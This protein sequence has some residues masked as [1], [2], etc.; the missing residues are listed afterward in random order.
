MGASY[1]KKEL[2]IYKKSSTSCPGCGFRNDFMI[3][4]EISCS[5]HT[6]ENEE[7]IFRKLESP[8]VEF[9]TFKNPDRG[10]G[11]YSTI[12]E[13]A[14]F[15]EMLV[16]PQ[17]VLEPVALEY[18]DEIKEFFEI[19]ESCP[20]RKEG[21]R[22]LFHGMHHGCE[23]CQKAEKMFRELKLRHFMMTDDISRGLSLHRPAFPSPKMR[24]HHVENLTLDISEQT[25][26]EI[27][28]RL[29]EH[30]EPK[31]VKV[32]PR[33]QP[34]GYLQSFEYMQLISPF[35]FDLKS[36][37]PNIKIL[38]IIDHSFDES[39]GSENYDL[40]PHFL[41]PPS[42]RVL[43]VNKN[44]LDEKVYGG[45]MS[46]IREITDLLIDFIPESY[47]STK[48][49]TLSPDEPLNLTCIPVENVNVSSLSRLRRL[50]CTNVSFNSNP[51]SDPEYP[52]CEIMKRFN[53]PETLE[54]FE[55][56]V[57]SGM[58]PF[59]VYDSKLSSYSSFKHL[60][61]NL[62]C[63]YPPNI[64]CID[65]STPFTI[66]TKEVKS[67]SSKRSSSSASAAPP[68]KEEILYMW[69]QHE[70][71]LDIISAFEVCF[72][73]DVVL[74]NFLT[75]SSKGR[76]L[77]PHSSKKDNGK[78]AENLIRNLHLLLSG[79]Q[80]IL[81]PGF[82]DNV[83][84]N[85]SDKY[86]DLASRSSAMMGMSSSVMSVSVKP[87]SGVFI[88]RPDKQLLD[89]SVDVTFFNKL[90]RK[91]VNG[92]LKHE[93][94]YQD[95]KR[96]L[97]R[98]VEMRS[99]FAFI[100]RCSVCHLA[101]S[102]GLLK[103]IP[104]ESLPHYKCVDDKQHEAYGVP[105]NGCG[106]EWNSM[107]IRPCK[108]NKYQDD[109]FA[110]ER[111]NPILQL[112]PTFFRRNPFSVSDISLKEYKDK[113][114]HFRPGEAFKKPSSSDSAKSPSKGS[115]KSP[116]NRSPKGSSSGGGT[117]RRILKKYRLS[118]IKKKSRKYKK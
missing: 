44:V 53:L 42:V 92:I 111:M 45:F 77:V 36:R 115:A 23:P 73:H 75:I 31:I 80:F 109:D 89:Q 18:S 52:L 110:R 28:R 94:K 58:N 56:P 81:P 55:V 85:V 49:P 116:S 67:V 46:S 71:I 1:S 26:A 57:T 86:S 59:V 108:C 11:E 20:K 33:N 105:G 63:V 41:L 40:L 112:D 76:H 24:F 68:R 47:V 95:H 7:S 64:Q 97:H 84:K 70:I 35:A 101:R 82:V 118:T 43:R 16:T 19:A 25:S 51:R 15:L 50:R 114:N 91:V 4:K 69:D 102:A 87:V 103:D 96:Y 5:Y 113:F 62:R 29:F 2:K 72:F 98:D 30:F 107:M 83:V 74:D 9:V 78:I 3:P 61:A 12:C 79:S 22:L 65:I 90:K 27:K 88:S 93:P 104:S 60:A 99:I 17:P 38:T 37:F 8:N 66:S 39:K 106:A 48:E 21:A 14:T 117:R 32:R 6:K 34:S 100:C 54:S 13:L 10:S